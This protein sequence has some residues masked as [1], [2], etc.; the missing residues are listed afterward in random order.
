MCV[1]FWASSSLDV[2]AGVT[3]EEGHAGFFIHL[4]YIP[5]TVFSVSQYSH[6]TG[7][8]PM[9]AYIPSHRRTGHGCALLRFVPVA[10]VVT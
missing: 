4:L 9:Y 5:G 6:N 3:Q 2:P 8:A 1:F 10:A 7:V